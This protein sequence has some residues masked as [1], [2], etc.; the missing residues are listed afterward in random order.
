MKQW[1]AERDSRER[2]IISCCGTVV[3]LFLFFISI[4]FPVNS[5]VSNL[6]DSI[7]KKEKEL[8]WYNNISAEIKALEDNGSKPVGKFKLFDIVGK[9]ARKNNLHKT[10][11]VDK[12]GDQA[13]RVEI[14]SVE[15]DRLMRWLSTLKEDYGITII[16]AAIKSTRKKGYVEVKELKLEAH[17]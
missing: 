17:Q 5:K 15:F 3:L 6:R 8:V 12:K 13:V 2:M 16:N 4:W 1:W 11:K 14:K 7:A 9:T 10:I